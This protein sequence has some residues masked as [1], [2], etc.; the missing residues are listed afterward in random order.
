VPIDTGG[1]Y[2]VNKEYTAPGGIGS[3]SRF[4]ELSGVGATTLESKRLLEDIKRLLET[5][6]ATQVD[7]TTTIKTGNDKTAFLSK[8]LKD[9]VDATGVYVK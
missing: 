8:K 6:N 1:D 4:A 9:A 7:Q 3:K 2:G 5:L